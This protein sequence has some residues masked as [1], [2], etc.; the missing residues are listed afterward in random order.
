[1]TRTRH[2][3]TYAAMANKAFRHGVDHDLTGQQFSDAL[4]WPKTLQL[5][6]WMEHHGNQVRGRWFQ[7]GGR[8]YFPD[9]ETAAAFC[10]KFGGRRWSLADLTTQQMLTKA[11][12]EA[13]RQRS[14]DNEKSPG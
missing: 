9:E 11:A 14:A 10:L 2:R 6:H 3:S 8:F 7:F 4:A 13:A 5:T 1:M 12:R